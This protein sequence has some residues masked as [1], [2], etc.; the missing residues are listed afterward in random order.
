MKARLRIIISVVLI[1]TTAC[2]MNIFAFAFENA[3]MNANET[4]LINY[5]E[6]RNMDIINE[7]QTNDIKRLEK[8]NHIKLS[9]KMQK[10]NEEGILLNETKVSISIKDSIAVKNYSFKFNLPKNHRMIM[11]EKYYE[12]NENVGDVSIKE[13]GWVYILDDCGNVVEVI[14]PATAL[15]AKGEE[16]KSY[17]QISENNILTQTVQFDSD[18]AFPIVLTTTSTKPQN[19]KIEDA[20]STC[21]ID[22]NVIGLGSFISGT[23]CTVLTEAAKK[24]IKNEIIKK[25]GAKF[26]PILSTASWAASGYSA[27]MSAAGYSY[28]NVTVAYEIWAFFKHQGGRWVEG[29]QYKN[30]D[31]RLQLVA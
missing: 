2:S 11:S 16:I 28:T 15:D 22:H 27:I 10:V 17:Y 31:V 29:R 23:A 12:E 5:P 6:A 20:I 24:K 8:V 26:I 7:F 19:Y 9:A 3:K 18:D 1:F 30:V 21:T 4:A 25:L 14:E 13:K